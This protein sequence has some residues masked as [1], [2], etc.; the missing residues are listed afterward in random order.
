MTL[1][2]NILFIH[3]IGGNIKMSRPRLYNEPMTNRIAR[4]PES[5]M[6]ELKSRGVNFTKYIQQAY[7]AEKESNWKYDPLE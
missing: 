5:M 2:L 3:E 1:K 7:K 6:I 4:I